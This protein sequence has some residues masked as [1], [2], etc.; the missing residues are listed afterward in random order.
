[1]ILTV[2]GNTTVDLTLF[3]SEFVQQRTIR[4]TDAVYSPG[5]KPTDASYILGELGIRSKAIGF[6]AGA[7]GRKLERMLQA[8][9]ADVDFIE[10]EGETRI[11]VNIV[12]PSEAWQ[13]TITTVTMEVLPKHLAA[14]RE[15]YIALL[16]ETT[17]V[18]LGGTLPRGMDETFY[19]D[20]IALARSQ[21]I[22]VIFDAAEPN[23]SAGL[24]SQPNYI[25]P[26]HH[27]LEGLVGYPIE[28]TADAF[29]AGQTVLE[30]FGVSS[31]I[32]LGS[33]GGLAVLPPAAYR[34]PPLDITVVSATGAGD[35][36]LAGLAASIFRNQPVEDGLRLGFAAASAVC[37]MPGTADCRREDVERLLP[38]VQLI[39][40][41]PD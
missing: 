37:L 30:R 24:K 40:Y 25:K 22:P 21:G 5:G 13:T 11:C 19:T 38:Q 23:L 26:N 3:L 41:Q 12:V 18:V 7:T 32:S 34:I 8:K 31:I 33:E 27:E 6:Y 29:R 14:L 16:P 20:F 4:A 35:A 17:C 36:I 10:V 9:G 2:T 28:T 15:K 39:P 1:M